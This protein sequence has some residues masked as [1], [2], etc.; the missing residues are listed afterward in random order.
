MLIEVYRLRYSLFI[1]EIFTYQLERYYCITFS[2]QPNGS[3]YSNTCIEMSMSTKDSKFKTKIKQNLT[4][5]NRSNFG[6][7]V[8]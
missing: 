6:K 4:T 8:K 1:L 2:F 3:F 7:R 5:D